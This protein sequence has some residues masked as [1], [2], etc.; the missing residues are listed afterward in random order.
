MYAQDVTLTGI[1]VVEL[2]LIGVMNRVAQAARE[3]GVR[4][5]DLHLVALLAH[6]DDAFQ[7]ETPALLMLGQRTQLRRHIAALGVGRRRSRLS[8]PVV[9]TGNSVSS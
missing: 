3:F 6:L 2:A 1:A 4:G 8:L 5:L 7:L 9:T